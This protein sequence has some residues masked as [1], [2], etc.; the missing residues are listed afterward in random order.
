MEVHRCYINTEHNPA[1]IA[2]RPETWIEKKHL[3]FHGPAFLAADKR[4]WPRNMHLEDHVVSV[5][6]A[7]EGLDEVQTLILDDRPSEETERTQPVVQMNSQLQEIIDLQSSHFP[8]EFKGKETHLTRNLGL[9]KDVD[10]ILRCKG[11]LMHADLSYETQHPILLPKDCEFTTKIIKDAHESHYHVGVPHTLSVIRHR[12]WI[13]QGR[14]QVRKVIQKCP[15]CIKHGGGPY[16]LPKTPALPVE[17]VKYSSPFTYTGVDYFGPMHVETSNGKEKRWICLFTCLVVRAIHLEVVQDMRAE[18]FL[19]ALRRFVASRGAPSHIMSDNAMQFKLMSEV[20][21]SNYCTQNKIFWK[22]IPQLAPWHGGVYERL[23]SVVKHCLKRTLEKHLLSDNQLLTV[24]KEVEA[25]VNTRPLTYVGADV[26]YVLKPADFLSMGKCLELDLPI[27]QLTPATI[28]KETLVEGWRRGQKVMKEF[29]NMFIG[30]YLL[31]LREKYQHSPKQPRVMSH[32]KPCVGDIVQI[33]GEQKNRNQWKVGRISEL[34][35]GSDGEVR[36]A[37]V[38][39]ENTDF[40]RSIGHLYPLEAEVVSEYNGAP[41]SVNLPEVPE[42]P[43]AVELDQIP[44][45][46]LQ[47]QVAIDVEQLGGVIEEITG[48]HQDQM[49]DVGDELV[50]TSPVDAPGAELSNQDNNDGRP[51]SSAEDGPESPA[52]D[53][54]VRRNAAV[55]AREKIAEWTRQ[56]FALL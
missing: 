29:K 12:Y 19:L 9:F 20:L 28:T 1:D 39:V 31:N 15:Q 40:I 34:I 46:P 11:R 2:T 23:V 26:D 47:D 38:R 42:V 43:T 24:L 17:R 44:A 6:A 3:W 50:N 32:I 36:V 14:V 21:S 41:N 7:A 13:P 54:R 49:N 16:Q 52:E 10:G 27:D 37:R 51:E 8:E 55:R 35:K 33:K 30:Q 25:V 45:Y 48:S 22:F 18:E 56:L 53:G 5:S 4:T